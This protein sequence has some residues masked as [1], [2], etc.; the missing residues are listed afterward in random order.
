MHIISQ[1]TVYVS[2]ELCIMMRFTFI[3]ELGLC[4]AV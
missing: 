1:A 4:I 2:E 3:V